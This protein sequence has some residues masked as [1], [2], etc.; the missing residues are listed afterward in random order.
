MV[1]A[2]LYSDRLDRVARP[3]HTTVTQGRGD[4]A[5]G[6]TGGPRDHGDATAQ[7]ASIRRPRHG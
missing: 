6:T 3:V 7:G 4:P 2:R 1:S 5:P